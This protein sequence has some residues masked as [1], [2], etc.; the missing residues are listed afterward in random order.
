MSSLNASCRQNSHLKHVT[1]R[2]YNRR[3]KRIS[4]GRKHAENSHA[5]PVL[6]MDFGA[7]AD[8]YLDG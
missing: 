7:E 4:S 6:S 1:V 8:A 5:R 3:A 2:T